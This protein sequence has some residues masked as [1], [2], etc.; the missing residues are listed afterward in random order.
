MNLKKIFQHPVYINPTYLLYVFNLIII[1]GVV[2][3]L[4][5]REMILGSAF[6]I[7]FYLFLLPLEDGILFFLANIPFFV[8][9][10]VTRGFDSLNIWRIAV[11]ILFARLLFVKFFSQAPFSLKRFKDIFR[12]IC[13]KPKLNKIEV[14]TLVYF[15]VGFLSVLV[16]QDKISALKRWFYLAEMILAYPL[17]LFL[18]R[19]KKLLVRTLRFILVSVFLILIIALGQLCF[20]YF[21]NL[22]YFWGWWTWRIAQTFYGNNLANIVSRANTWFSYYDSNYPTLRSFST[23]TDSHSFS[24]YFLLSSPLILWLII[25][26][27]LREKKIERETILLGI[28]FILMQFLVVLSGTRGIWLT[29]SAPLALAGFFV[30]KGW[31]KSL[32]KFVLSGLI[33]FALMLP[34][35]SL[36][37]SIPQFNVGFEGID[38]TLTLKRFRS[39]IDLEETSN[40]GRLLIWKKSVETFVKRPFL[41]VGIGNFP[42]VLD[43]DVRLQKA[44]STAH[45]VYLN[46]GV[47]MGLLGLMANVLIFF[48][49]LKECFRGIKGKITPSLALRFLL[50]F[51]FIWVFTY[52][53]FDIAIFD[54]RVMILFATEIG[55]LVAFSQEQSQTCLI[56]AE[57]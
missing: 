17:T 27:Y 16:A 37:L 52:S 35:S 32:T 47:E 12:K 31:Q 13:Q 55:I 9:L 28:A 34:L 44:G 48:Y 30:I 53:L 39:I 57:E 51:Y 3:H 8:A 11:L 56:Q 25:K 15:A 4:L 29:F 38:Q 10:P 19:E 26:N 6:L 24:L 45:N 40:K 46:S 36:F 22:G 33:I 41:G 21:V 54:A 14:W 23:F 18:I 7:F 1:F 2:F 50:G 49:I 5:P 20:S 43:E 42:V